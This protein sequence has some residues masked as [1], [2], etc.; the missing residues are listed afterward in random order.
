[1]TDRSKDSRDTDHRIIAELRRDARQSNVAL[2]KQ[3]GLTEGAVRRRIDNLVSSGVLRFVA[4]ADPAYLGQHAHALLRIRCAPHLIDEVIA[5][6][7]LI[8]EL[9]RVYLC[10]GPF[11]LTTVGH[12]GST[13]E[14]RDFTVSRLG[15]I[16]GIVEI[17]TDVVL[18]I[19]EPMEAAP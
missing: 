18:Q 7:R 3:V 8:P 4:V 9:E 16:D 5:E 2:A 11:D 1:M 14:L 12:F 10:T 17:Q 6:L 13:D 15:A 19:V